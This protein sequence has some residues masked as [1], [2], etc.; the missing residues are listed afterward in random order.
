MATSGLRKR[1]SASEN[2][3]IDERN[4]VVAKLGAATKLLEEDRQALRELCSTV[5]KVAAKQDIISEG[6][7]PEHVHAI[8]EGW[9]ARYKVLPDGSRQIVAFLIPGDF[10][11]LHVT[12][13]R[14]MDH[15]IVALT[16]AR[17]AYVPQVLMDDLTR[18]R[19]EVGRALWRATLIDESVLRAWIVNIGGRDAR[20]RI[21]HLFCELH[22]RMSLV[23]LTRDGHFD[24]P[25]TQEVIAEAMGLTPVHVNRTLQ[26]LRAENLI[27]LRS[28]MMTIP[29]SNVFSRLPA[30]IPITCT[31]SD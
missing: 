21:A 20:E 16:P 14:E 5:R 6:D 1:S 27:V 7:K 18:D 9:A 22:A 24:L 13:L 2:H 15:G 11:D 19:V 4:P 3:Q 17:V 23:G 10:C 26:E 29:E 8:L 12:I 30:S 28:G 25:W 31:A